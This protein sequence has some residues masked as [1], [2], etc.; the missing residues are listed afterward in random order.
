MRVSS[1]ALQRIS[2]EMKIQPE[3]LVPQF[4]LDF[5]QKSFQDVA[6]PNSCYRAKFICFLLLPEE[7]R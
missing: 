7:I 6:S 3:L 1:K 2:M 4:L 5:L